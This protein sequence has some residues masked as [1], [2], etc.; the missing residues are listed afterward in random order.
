[1]KSLKQTINEKLILNNNTKTKYNYQP[2]TKRELN[3]LIKQ[4]IEERGNDGY[5]N[6]IDT[7]EITDMSNL[8]ASFPKFNGDISLWDTSNVKEMTC[9]FDQCNKFNCDI[10]GW[11]VSRVTHMT[12]MFNACWKFNQDISG[13]DVSTVPFM[14][15]MFYECDNFEQDLSKWNLKNLRGFNSVF[16]ASKLENKKEFWPKALQ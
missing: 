4:L 6:D 14:N 12:M 7:S 15:Y 3:D 2:K 10:S 13:W 5:F 9:M 16:T 1:M 11:D 8:F